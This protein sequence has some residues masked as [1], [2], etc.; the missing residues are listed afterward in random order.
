[1]TFPTSSITLLVIGSTGVASNCMLDVDGDLRLTPDV[2]GVLLLRYLLG[3][4]DGALTQGVTLAGTRNNAAA[5]SAFIG[6]ASAF[7]VFGRTPPQAMNDGVVLLRILS[8][9]PDAALLNGVSVP[10]GAPYG[11]GSAVRG[12]VNGKCNTQF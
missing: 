11:T 6:N 10:A 1:M 7:D 3:F 5:I 12:F 2:D 4:R 9:M 8:G